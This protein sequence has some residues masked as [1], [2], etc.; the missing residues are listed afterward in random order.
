ML[1]N[2]FLLLVLMVILCSVDAYATDVSGQNEK[3]DVAIKTLKGS[4]TEMTPPQAFQYLLS[5]S[6]TTNV[7]V[8]NTL[9]V[10]YSS[11]IGT[12]ADVDKA[13]YYFKRA[14]V[15]GFLPAYKNLG[16]LFKNVKLRDKQDLKKACFYFKTGAEKGYS[17]CFYYYGFMLYKGLGCKQD[18]CKAIEFFNKAAAK[19]H[20]ASLYMLGLCYRNGYG[21]EQNFEM[22]KKYLLSSANLGYQPAIDELKNKYPEVSGLNSD[23]ES[24]G[25]QDGMPNFEPNI[26]SVSSMLGNHKGVIVTYDWSGKYIVSQKPFDISLQ[27]VND[28]IKGSISFGENKIRLVGTFDANGILRFTDN[29]IMLYDRYLGDEKVKYGVD[30]ASIADCGNKLCGNVS[31]YSYAL[32]E[33]E[34]PMYFEIYKEG[35]SEIENMPDGNNLIS[36]TPNPFD[37]EIK[38]SFKSKQANIN[39]FVY[40][41]EQGGF[42]V[43]RYVIGSVNEGEN[44]IVLQPKLRSGAYVLSVQV[45]NNVLRTIILK[46]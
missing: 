24:F 42:V 29:N 15:N 45:G 44:T 25:F 18:Y 43:D 38:V 13:V 20:K 7:I 10:A 26:S 39:A 2:K 12:E 19:R 17:P 1:K 40:I 14:A 16:M 11:G 30:Y 5:V 33:P 31:L 23:S 27:S 36:V 28:T 3:V 32:M 4:K 41:Y 9:G 37:N 22:A 34:K 6:D 8:A 35:N 21:T 46:K